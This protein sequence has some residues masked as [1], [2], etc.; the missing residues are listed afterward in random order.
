MSDLFIGKVLKSK[1]GTKYIVLDNDKIPELGKA[2]KKY[3]SENIDGKAKEDTY[4]SRFTVSICKKG[5]KDPDFV[6]NSLVVRGLD[7]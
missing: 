4:K 6:L 7:E 3:Y 5:P 2:L 1:K